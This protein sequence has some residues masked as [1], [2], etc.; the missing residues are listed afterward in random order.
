MPIAR[1]EMPDGRIARFEVPDGTTPE[2]AHSMMEAHFGGE[3]PAEPKRDPAADRATMVKSEIASFLSPLRGVKDV[4]DTG[5]ELLASGYDKITGSNEADRVKAMNDAGK[6]EFAQDTRGSMVA[7]V[8]RIA[9][10]I[11]ATAPVGGALAA[12]VRAAAPRLANAL[13]SGGFSTGAAAAPGLGA[14]AADMGLRMAGG[15]VT[16]GVAAGL[17]DPD[18]AGAGAAL[19]AALPPALKAV[20]ATGNALGRVIAGP[21]VP[22]NI[23][24]GVEAARAAGLVVPPTQARPTLANRLMEGF[25]GKITTAQNASARNQ[26]VLN[27]LAKKAIGADDLTP[28]GLAAV[29]KTANSAYDQLAQVGQFKAD[30]AFK[31]ALEKAGASTKEMQKNFPE[32]VNSKVDDLVSGLSSRG[33]FDAQSTIEAIKQFRSNGS[34]NRIAI[35]PAQKALGKAQ[36]Q[37]A[38]ALED[39]I[40]RNLQAAGSKNLLDGYRAARQTL[41]KVY[42]VEKALNPASGN[43]DAKKFAAL[44]KKGRPLTGELKT[45]A[46][47]GSQFP[48]A[49]QTLEGMGSLPQSSPLDWTAAG[50]ASL[51][52]SN[53]LMMAGVLARPAARAATLSP[54]VQNR[55]ATAPAG[56]NALAQLLA[57]PAVQQALYRSQPA[58]AADR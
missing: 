53:P 17:I 10:N 30:D 12:P 3:K 51:A 22:E 21:T 50:M 8:G 45:I 19:G 37:I 34:A 29:R 35:D 55:L 42:D 16:G 25:A 32:L 4:I 1:F 15:G 49:A 44:L 33:E 9:G 18:S 20:G 56:Q 39:M 11:A 27:E 47:F 6:A 52:T 28:E 54:M 31:A 40:D 36:M 24:A 26:P 43:V 2:Q 23:R 57:D 48:K 13:A 46:E 7:P 38:G 5:A 14:R 41:A 58:L